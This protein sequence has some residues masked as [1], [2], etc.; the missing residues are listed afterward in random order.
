MRAGRP[1]LVRNA[2]TF[3]LKCRGKPLA[4]GSSRQPMPRIRLS[5]YLEGRQSRGHRVGRVYPAGLKRSFKI[6]PGKF[7]WYSDW[8]LQNVLYPKTT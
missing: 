4:G 3:S 6:K 1:L 2:L 7:A 5:I 8:H